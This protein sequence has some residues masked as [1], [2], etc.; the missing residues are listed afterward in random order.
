M[1][2]NPMRSGIAGGVVRARRRSAGGTGGARTTAGTA[3]I[4]TPFQLNKGT[5]FNPPPLP[6]SFSSHAPS[7][8]QAD[9]ST[10]QPL[11]LSNEL[12][13]PPQSLSSQQG[14]ATA[15]RP[16]G[17]RGGATAARTERSNRANT[18]T[19]ADTRAAIRTLSNP[20]YVAGDKFPQAQSSNCSRIS[21]GGNDSHHSTSPSTNAVSNAGDI[22]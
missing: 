16:V 15:V 14:A 2:N 13:I 7:S 18:A 17:S 5:L 11:V 4:G 3:G 12:L 6:Q 1:S 9:I 21:S 19:K 8:Q 22:V 10:W 20:L